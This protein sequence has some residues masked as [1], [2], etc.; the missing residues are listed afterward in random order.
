VGPAYLPA[1]VFGLGLD[2]GPV[3]APQAPPRRLRPV[4]LAVPVRRTLAL[5]L[6]VRRTMLLTWDDEGLAVPEPQSDAYARGE[7]VDVPLGPVA[8]ATYPLT[9]WTFAFLVFDKPGGTVYQTY[10]GATVLTGGPGLVID[11]ATGLGTA[12]MDHQGTLSHPAGRLEWECWRTDAGHETRIGRGTFQV[13]EE[14][15]Y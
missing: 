14:G 6:P 1:L 7:A 15:L 4:A 3:A 8:G 2:A 13:E 10:G 5:A 9:G 11:P 12:K